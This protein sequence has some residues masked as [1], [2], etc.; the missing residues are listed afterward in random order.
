MPEWVC[1]LRAIN[2]GARNKVA[3]PQLRKALAAE[4]F[5]NVR[6]YVQSGNVVLRSAHGAAGDVAAA[7]R[8]L[9]KVEFG[10]DT[11]VVVRTPQQIR[12]ILAWCPFPEEAASTPTAVHVVH[13]D[14]KPKA[15]LVKSTLAEDWSPD[16]LEIRGLEACIRYAT[17]MRASRLQHAALVRR[18][19]VDGTARNWRTEVAIANL[20]S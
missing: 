15:A 3:M 20:L 7:V 8:T 18:L 10:V 16:S 14:A 4:G 19:G 12:D 17:T 1:L 5:E 9:I 6:T 2:L 11:P 13:L